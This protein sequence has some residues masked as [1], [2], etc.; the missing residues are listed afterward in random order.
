[1]KSI[2]GKR[3]IIAIVAAIMVVTSFVKMPV[4]SHAYDSKADVRTILEIPS[5]LTGKTVILHTN[6]MHGVVGRYALVASV[7]ENLKDRGADVV[8]VDAG[9]FS[10]GTPYVNLSKGADA[11]VMMNSAGYDIVTIGNHEFGNG[12]NNMMTNLSRGRFKTIC[13]NA[14]NADGS[15]IFAPNY[16]YT[17][18]YGLEIGF[19]GLV[20]PETQS[21]VHPAFVS[22][23]KFL[24]GAELASCAQQQVDDL[25]AKGADI[26]ICLSHLGVYD[27]SAIGQNRSVDVYGK[28][29]G[30]D[31]MID[32][33]S[34]TIMTEGEK[35]EPV[36][37]TGT[38]LETLGV[39]IIDNATKSIEDRFLITQQNLQEEVRTAAN[40]NE[41]FKRVDA[42]YGGSFATTEVVLNG[43]KS[44]GNRTEETN[45]GDLVADGLKWSVMKNPGA[46]LV[47]ESH[48]I[49]ITN[50]GG[51]RATIKAGSMS[52][53]DINT[54]LP[55]GNTVAVVYITGAE[56]LEVLEAS[57]FCTPSPI[58]AFP[59]TS[60]IKYTV[61]TTKSYDKGAAYTGS[62]YFGPASIKRVTIQSI[63]G[64]PFSPTDTYAV[65][66]N[67]FCSAGGDTYYVFKNAS[68][69]FNTGIVM[70]DAVID[71]IKEA[72]GGKITA[73]KYGAP[74]GDQT[75]IS[76][77]LTESTPK[78]G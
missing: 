43:E 27:E 16:I 18:T 41:I 5:D 25:K 49:A 63:N 78:A 66:T 65:V 20:T 12:Y 29:K 32:G 51:I 23:L 8:L 72:L 39:V 38:K 19:F 67:D 4:V 76:T 46:L 77:G 47:D 1:M 50:G 2:I 61:D 30:I 33:H 17:G 62:T 52:K 70:D 3:G 54:V 24:A 71:Y 60:G 42:D 13:A 40:A 34:H 58:G 37:S 53:K 7:K 59:Q 73:D 15:S 22:G 26:V 74:R 36:Q 75:I 44:P 31:L 10:Y 48:V 11:I 56:L 64:Q 14:F 69:K 35:G 68:S 28:T 45:L 55:F 57:T 9:D 6:D 21:K